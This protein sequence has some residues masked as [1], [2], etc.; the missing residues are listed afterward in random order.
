MKLDS[1][2]VLGDKGL[3]AKRLKTYESRG[4]QLAMADAVAQAIDSRQHLVV[5]AGTGV[6]KSFAYLVPAILAAAQRGDDEKP[7]RI[8]VSTHTISL[9]EQLVYK[10]IPFLNAVLPVEFSAVLVKG[11]SNYLS[12]RRLQTAN[13]RG[14]GT[15]FENDSLSQLRRI[16]EWSATT[17]DGSRSDLPFQPLPE[18]WDEVYSDSGN[19]LGK[20]CP[21]YDDCFYYRARRRVWNANLLVVNHALFFSDLALRRD[22]ASVLPDYDVAIFDEAHTLE[23]VAGDYLGV[24]TSLGQFRYL[25]NRLYNDRQ[26]KGLLVIH[27]LKRA[28]QLVQRLRSLTEEFFEEIRIFANRRPRQR[29]PAQAAPHREP[30]RP[31][32]RDLSRELADSADKCEDE[33]K[34]AELTGM[35]DRIQQMAVSLNTWLTQKLEDGVYWIEDVGGRQ[36]NVKLVSAPVEVGPVLRDELFAKVPSVILTSATLSVGK[37][38]FSYFRGRIGLTQGTDL[39]LGSP[40]DYRSQAKLII[41][42]DMPDPSSDARKFEGEMCR[43]ASSGTSSRPAD[44]RLCCSPAIAP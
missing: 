34:K 8:V 13:E 31:D 29:A 4:E 1:Q 21:T 19:C 36:R 6:G 3:I 15:L 42:D 44:K 32:S 23:G 5:E 18:V 12:L 20:R 25:Y 16:G 39:K 17:A 7:L 9:Q 33:S 22:G 40:F 27:E 14:G 41:A 24:A 28:Q 43:S 26:G 38:D 2:A 11:R 10:D 37:Q 30:P 35:A